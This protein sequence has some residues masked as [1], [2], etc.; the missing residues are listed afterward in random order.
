MYCTEAVHFTLKPV[1][2]TVCYHSYTTIHITSATLSLTPVPFHL[3]DSAPSLESSFSLNA[4]N[5]KQKN[6]K[7]S[8][9]KIFFLRSCRAW[10]TKTGP[11]MNTQG[12][13]LRA[14][15]LILPQKLIQPRPKINVEG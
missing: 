6:V 15:L 4:I 14:N 2:R 10:F 11:D 5:N 9:K 12:S 1:N 7:T 13:L 3:A 8:E